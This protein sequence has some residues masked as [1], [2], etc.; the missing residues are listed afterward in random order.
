MFDRYYV[1]LSTLYIKQ[2]K[3]QRGKLL[4]SF[5][6]CSPK[7][8]LHSEVFTVCASGAN[9]TKGQ[10][11][12][13]FNEKF[14]NAGH[15]VE[16]KRVTSLRLLLRDIVQLFGHVVVAPGRAGDKNESSFEQIFRTARRGAV[17]R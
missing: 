8:R 14:D 6:L 13:N 15:I 11:K 12:N 5:H 7:I 3:K 9:R 2:K 16:L 1:V 4:S 10:T 17:Q